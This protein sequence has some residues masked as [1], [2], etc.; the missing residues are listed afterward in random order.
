MMALGEVQWP[1][2]W[3]WELDLSLRHLRTRMVQREFSETDLRTMLEDATGY[4]E[5]DDDP[6]RYVIETQFNGDPWEVVVEPL[7]D[8]ETLVVI[9]AWRQEP[10]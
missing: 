8:D 4:H 1:D 9:T 7:A 6:R 2:W 10:S 3:E 5:D